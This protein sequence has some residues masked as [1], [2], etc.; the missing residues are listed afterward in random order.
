MNRSEPQLTLMIV[1]QLRQMGELLEDIV[2]KDGYDR[3]SEA[4]KPREL[5]KDD[6]ATAYNVP[7]KNLKC[8]ITGLSFPNWSKTQGHHPPQLINLH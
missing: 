1:N 7:K 8:M 4:S 3:I 2:D 6:Y 5:T